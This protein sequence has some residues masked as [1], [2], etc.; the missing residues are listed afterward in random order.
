MVGGVG[1]GEKGM[2]GWRVGW[3]VGDARARQ[4]RV[5]FEKDDW[6]ICTQKLS[7]DFI[8]RLIFTP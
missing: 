4:S 5:G 2:A 6:S 7:I 1:D 3:A 8:I